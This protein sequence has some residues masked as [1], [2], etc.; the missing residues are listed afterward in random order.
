MYRVSHWQ[1]HHRSHLCRPEPTDPAPVVVV[2]VALVA[3]AVAL[4][5]A[6]AAAVISPH[7][8]SSVQSIATDPQKQA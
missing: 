5:A 4:V 8:P 7:R 1:L 3:V 6:A 2:V